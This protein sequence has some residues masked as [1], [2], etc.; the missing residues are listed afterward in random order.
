MRVLFWSPAFWP[1]IGG[2]QLFGAQLLPALRDRGYEIS[3]VTRRYTSAVP[4]Q[5]TF[6]GIPIRRFSFRSALSPGNIEAMAGL[7]R[8]LSELKRAFAPDLIHVNAPDATTFFHLT[9]LHAHRAPTLLT[10]HGLWPGQSGENHSILQQVL[11]SSTWTT[12]CSL[13]TLQEARRIAPRID[14]C[15][16]VIYNGRR[17]PDTE[18]GP[19]PF[20]RP[21]LLCLGRLSK[22]KGFDLA[23]HAFAYLAPRFPNVR[24]VI[25]GDGPERDALVTQTSELGLSDRV[26]FVG[27]VAPN[28][29]PAL[30][31]TATVVLVPSRWE[32]FGL[33]A[34]EAGLME[35]PVVASSVGGLNE[36]VKDGETG[37]L[38][39]VDADNLA[40]AIVYL[41]THPERAIDM[42]RAAREH[43]VDQFGWSRHVQAYDD[44]YRKLIEESRTG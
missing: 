36:I 9:T 32:G 13:Y 27:W 8:E 24:V 3:V 41:L 10:L 11:E 7:R 25:A 22:E 21:K 1:E 6:E 16:S 28:D 43:A 15:S 5:D 42:G 14:S 40:D 39:P 34:L 30:I 44:L 20:G 12:S 4:L 29:V 18:P 2:V 37:I 23:I 17:T 26:D 33:A 35:R 38:V 31:G 19:L